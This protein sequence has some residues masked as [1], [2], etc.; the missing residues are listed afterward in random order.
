M[1]LN[2]GN[3][4]VRDSLRVENL[5]HSF[6]DAGTSVDVLKG[7]SLE[8]RSSEITSIAGPSGCGKSTLLY[9]MGLLDRPCSGKIFMN[10]VEV[11]DLNDIDR[12]RA[13]NKSIGFVFQFHHLLPEFTALENVCIPA[14]IKKQPTHSRCIV[15]R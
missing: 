11:Q 9:L 13:R 5:C 3:H 8:A 7:V 4:P 2:G 10:D 6:V 15:K 12:T 1:D 14:F